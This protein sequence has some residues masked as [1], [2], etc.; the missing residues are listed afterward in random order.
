MKEKTFQVTVNVIEDIPDFN[1]MVDGKPTINEVKTPRVITFKTLDQ[2]D[3]TQ[4]DLHFMIMS[5]YTSGAAKAKGKNKIIIEHRFALDIAQQF[6]EDMVIYNDDFKATDAAQV[7]TDSAA[8][9]MLGNSVIPEHVI[10]FFLKLMT[11]MT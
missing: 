11:S 4:H 9:M 2:R 3:Q 7:L 8:L 1:D 6:M 10:P 5:H